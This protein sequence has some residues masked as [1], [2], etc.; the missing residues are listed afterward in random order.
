MYENQIDESR[1]KY[2]KNSK[3]MGK[4]MGGAWQIAQKLLQKSYMQLF[5]FTLLRGF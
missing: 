3:Y 4:H 1:F 5:I 2:F